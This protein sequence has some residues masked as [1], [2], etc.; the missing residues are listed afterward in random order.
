MSKNQKREKV[1]Y[2]RVVSIRIK[3]YKRGILHKISKYL[4]N[5]SY[6]EENSFITAFFLYI[7]GF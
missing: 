4:N 5:Y 1:K 7:Y 2:K 3:N 6:M